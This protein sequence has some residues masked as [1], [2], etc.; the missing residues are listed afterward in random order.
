MVASNSALK[1]GT[2]LNGSGIKYKIIDVL[3]QGGFGITY[4]AVGEVLVN[5]IPGEMK[6]AIK[7]HFPPASCKRMDQAV[8]PD[9]DK[10]NAFRSSLSDFISEAKKLHSLGAQNENIVKVNEVFEENGTA[11]YVMQYINGESLESY[12]KSKGKLKY[13]EAIG[14]LSPIFDAV[15][16]LHKSRINHLDI[17]PENI[18]L[19]R[20]VDG[21]NPILI[22]FGLSVHYNKSGS[23]TS[24]KGVEG[25]SEGYSPLEQYAGIKKFSPATDIYALAATLLYTLTG[26]SP[27]N[28]LEIRLS[29]I[30]S[31][32]AS[33]VPQNAVDGLC[34]ALRQSYEDRTSSI[35]ALKAEL[36]LISGGGSITELLD[37]DR[38]NKKKRYLRTLLISLFIIGVIVIVIVLLTRK[39]S[40]SNP[41]L[42]PTPIDSTR[43]DSVSTGEMVPAVPSVPS[44]E[45][46]QSIVNTYALAKEANICIKNGEKRGHFTVSEGKQLKNFIAEAN[47]I[48]KSSEL[49]LLDESQKIAYKEIVKE[50]GNAQEAV[51]KF[52][53]YDASVNL[54]P[55]TD[56]DVSPV[57]QKT[58]ST[59]GTLQLG[60]G[61][62]RGGIKN[63]KPDGKG[64]ISF[65]SSHRVDRSSSAEANPGDY[66]IATYDNGS[67]IS[68]KLYDSAGNLIQTIIP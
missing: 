49:E 61:S 39:P 60:Y 10:L 37:K 67:L 59:Q 58:E 15:D 7:E 57:S 6:F 21:I 41:E 18:M 54:P 3:G 1:I 11:Y 68:G 2:V 51:R 9:D 65:T 63:G 4:L 52:K 47:L 25:V 17:K 53:I 5:N 26:K 20:G 22:D 45:L 33:I 8:V 44:E 28:A 13:H 64:R 50:A 62:W 12:V 55:R 35:K 36:G 14:L 48:G 32:I 43:I 66:F 27:K 29:E 42:P 19:H 38:E 24:P 23:Q 16:F 56:T 34:K 30:R 46:V 40:H 31:T